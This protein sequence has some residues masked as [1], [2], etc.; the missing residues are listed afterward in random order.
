MLYPAIALVSSLIGFV[1]GICGVSG[2][3][4]PIFLI[5]YCG[6][7]AA[8]GLFISYS[9]FLAGSAI[10]VRSYY[11]RGEVPMETALPLSLSSLAGAV[12]GAV[13]GRFFVSEHIT[14]VLYT[15]VLISGIMIFIQDFINRRKESGEQLR[16]R[17]EKSVLIPLGF[18]TALICSMAGAGGPVI[19]MPLLVVLGM[20]I[21]YAIGIALFDSM[22]IALPPILIYGSSVELEETVLPLLVAAAGQI[23]GILLGSRAAAGVPQRPVKLGVALFSVVFALWKLLG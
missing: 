23:L 17:L 16:E 11:S 6:F 1:I 3:L 10:G 22:F 12:C 19:V 9:C 18:V 20:P 8:S 13:I 4:L 5:N 15:V 21:R 14:K 2:F 7:P